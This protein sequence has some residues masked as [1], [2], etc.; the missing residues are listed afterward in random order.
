MLTRRE[1]DIFKTSGTAVAYPQ[2]EVLNSFLV[3]CSRDGSKWFR[4]WDTALNG[5]LP[6]FVRITIQIEEDG[7]PVEFSVLASPKVK[8]P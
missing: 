7:K 6:E 8:S 3:E 4:T 1:Q 2:I 5:S